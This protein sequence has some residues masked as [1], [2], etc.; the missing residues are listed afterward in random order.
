[1]Y[2]T[3]TT[4]D[5]TA[6]QFEAARKVLK[7]E[8]VPRVSK[9]PGFVKGFWSIRADAAQGLSFLVF[10]TKQNAENAAQMLRSATPPPGVKM[11]NAEI[12]EVIAD[13]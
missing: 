4:V 11:N 2:A 3:V 7:E 5:I 9:A 10:D 1:M 13:A 6:G 8:V 12:R